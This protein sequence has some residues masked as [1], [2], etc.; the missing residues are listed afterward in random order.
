MTYMFRTVGQVLGVALSAAILQATLEDDLTAQLSDR[1]LVDAIRHSTTI[2]PGL[3]AHIRRIAVD[4]Y[5][6]GLHRVWGFNLGLALLTLA[7]MSV[8]DNEHMPESPGGAPDE[9]A[10]TEG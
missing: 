9:S 7:I 2:I 1:A 5:A 8:A 6:H 10:D 4:A 3:P